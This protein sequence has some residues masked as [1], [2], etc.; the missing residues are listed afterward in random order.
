MFALITLVRLAA[1]CVKL[2]WASTEK[3][4]SAAIFVTL[5]TTS[6]SYVASFMTT[7][8]TTSLVTSAE[9]FT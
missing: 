5:S 7:M 4:N 2:I 1:L 8:T 9:S 6:L 3:I